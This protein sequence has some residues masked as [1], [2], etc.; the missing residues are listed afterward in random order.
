MPGL[1]EMFKTMAFEIVAEGIE[2]QNQLD[3]VRAAGITHAQGYFLEK[4][5]TADY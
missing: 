3:L 2:T 5:G 4:P 1:V